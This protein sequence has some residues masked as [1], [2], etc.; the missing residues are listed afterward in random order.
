MQL[1]IF[2][3]LMRTLSFSG[4]KMY[5][6]LTFVGIGVGQCQHYSMIVSRTQ[7]IENLEI[8]GRSLHS[9]S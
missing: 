9:D 7:G 4:W 5:K 6:N 3:G 2:G 8:K 1:F